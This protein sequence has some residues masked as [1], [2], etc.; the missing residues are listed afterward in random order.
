MYI[1]YTFLEALPSYLYDKMYVYE[2]YFGSVN[3]VA[4][5]C[6]YNINVQYR[7]QIFTPSQSLS[8]VTSSRGA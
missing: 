4:T 8:Q 6:K 1:L 7:T 5:S 2:L 3:L